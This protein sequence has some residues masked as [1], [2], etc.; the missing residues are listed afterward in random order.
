MIKNNAGSRWCSLCA[1]EEFTNVDT[2][3]MKNS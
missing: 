1:K 3:G 2:Y